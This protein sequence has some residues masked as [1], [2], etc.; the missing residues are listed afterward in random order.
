MNMA[1]NPILDRIAN[2]RRELAK[3]GL[4]GF[5]VPMADE[6][7]SEYV[8]ASAQRLAF[9]SG[10]TGSAGF[11]IILRD[12]SAF[13]T[14]GRYTLQAEQQLPDGAFIRFDSADKTPT[15]WLAEILTTGMK[16][17]FDPWL[18]TAADVARFEKVA[19]KTGASFVAVEK[20]P[21][22]I[23]WTDRPAAPVAPIHPHDIAY[24]GRTS[25]E[26]RMEIVAEMKTK[27]IGAVMVADPASI[28]WL[29][30]IRG[31][32]VPNTPLPLS[33]AVLHDDAQVEWFVDPRKITG[34][35]KT[36]LGND[37]SIKTPDDFPAA[38]DALGASGKLIRIDTQE[39]AQWIVARLRAAGAKLD[40]GNDPSV[41]PRARKNAAELEGA[42]SAH[43]RDGAALAK[44]FAWLDNNLSAG[45]ITEISAAEKLESIRAESNMFRGPSFDTIAGAGSHGAIV[46]Y[47]AAPTT[48]RRLEAGQIFLLDSGGQ[49]LDGTTD[50]TR[51]LALGPATAEMRD[52]FT[53]VLKGHIALASIRFPEG[54][55]GGDLDVLARQFLWAA[56]LDYSHGTGHGVGSYLG[57][58]EGPHGISRRSK[59]ALQPGMV[60]SN[61]PGYYKNGDY[62]IRIENLQVVTSPEAI[63]GG[64]RKM[65]GFEPLTLVPIDRKL[66]EVSLLT[67]AERDWLNAYHAR[68]RNSLR[69]LVDRG[70]LEWLEAATQ[71]I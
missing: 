6:Y 70:T 60:V 15:A 31:G 50:V 38:L 16:I 45:D 1:T 69:L 28:A 2:L 25:A 46:H 71:P 11:I 58:H 47:K 54:V 36:H 41:L 59:V 35:L 3:Q 9:I 66:I 19:Q 4:D 12:R 67:Q 29:L 39:T 23:I 37:I 51:T 42:R 52:R 68:V 32:D 53:R 27:N 48:N 33:F 44:F 14:D 61:E 17:G 62:G 43:R 21:I 24:A 10:F 26:K 18:H 49:Y 30:N 8:P 34:G 56:G 63:E 64:E 55:T 13:F 22:D 7:Q 65:L 20:N 57:V 5:L 40:E